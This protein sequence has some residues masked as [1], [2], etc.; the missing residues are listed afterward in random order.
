MNFLQ[1]IC[2][3]MKQAQDTMRFDTFQKAGDVLSR[4][5]AYAREQIQ[6]LSSEQI[7]AIIVKL[8]GKAALTPDDLNLVRL[9]IVGDA[10]SYVSM[11]NSFQ[12]WLTEFKRLQ[13]SLGDYE[14]KELT[15]LD[16]FN[17]RG[18]LEDA[19][20]VA[21]DISNFLE[22]KERI[23]KFQDVAGSK[24]GLDRETLVK[25]LEA[26]LRSGAL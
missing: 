14:G 4:G 21:Y 6:K 3:T 20:R 2:E 8:K 23:K 16:F 17:L 18:I 19:L 26:K 7:K 9:W 13:G 24:D 10:E 15:E 1:G 5:K 22:K 25:I 11:E 12:V